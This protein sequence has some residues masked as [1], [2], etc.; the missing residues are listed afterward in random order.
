MQYYLKFTRALSDFLRKYTGVFR[1][2]ASFLK[3]LLQHAF[4]LSVPS[5]NKSGEAEENLAYSA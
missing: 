4:C 5:Q 1:F 2:A 3:L